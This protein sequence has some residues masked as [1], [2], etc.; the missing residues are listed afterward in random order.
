MKWA[1]LQTQKGANHHIINLDPTPIQHT[2]IEGC[3]CK[4]G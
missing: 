4:L 2:Q 3:L 1:Y